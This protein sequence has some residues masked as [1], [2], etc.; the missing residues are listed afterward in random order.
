M[1]TRV[2]INSAVF[3]FIWSLLSFV[4]LFTNLRY[5]PLHLTLIA[6]LFGVAV[7]AILGF[8]VA[9]RR[10]KFITKNGETRVPLSTILFLV[11]GILIV[12]SFCLFFAFNAPISALATVIDFAYPILPPY[13]AM[14]A[15]LFFRW[16]RQHRKLI[17]ASMWT[18]RLY[19]SPKTD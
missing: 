7:G 16:E 5:V 2:A 1:G 13:L 14:E 15:I 17:L 9:K 11:G 6:V 4:H 19:V 18:N 8:A 12:L 3:A 10:L